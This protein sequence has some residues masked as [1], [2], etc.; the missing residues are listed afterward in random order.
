MADGT[1]S[2]YIGHGGG[3]I[4]GGEH[5]NVKQASFK[6]LK[7]SEKYL[8]QFSSTTVFPYPNIGHVKFYILT[9]NGVLAAE[10]NENILGEGRHKLSK[11]FYSG[12]DVLA[13]LRIIDEQRR[14]E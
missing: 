14:K 13:E 8:K 11:L 1:T 4:G 9:Y 6:F 5:E 10:G 3:I 7:T 2:L 12:H